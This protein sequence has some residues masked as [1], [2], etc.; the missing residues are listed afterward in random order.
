MGIRPDQVDRLLR[1]AA[2]Q[3]AQINENRHERERP[4]ASPRAARLRELEDDPPEWL[5]ST[6]GKCPVRSKSSAGVVLAWRRAA[7][8]IEDYRT[9]SCHD[10]PTD[11]IG[12][13]PPSR[14]R[15][16]HVRAQRAIGEVK[17][18]RER[19]DQRNRALIRAI[20]RRVPVAE[21]AAERRPGEKVDSRCILECA[22]GTSPHRRRRL[23]DEPSASRRPAVG[24]G[25]LPLPVLVP[26]LGERVRP[27]SGRP[28]GVLV[29]KG[30]QGLERAGE[31]EEFEIPC[32]REPAP[33]PAH[34]WR[35]EA[36]VFGVDDRR[37]AIPVQPMA[38]H[39]ARGGAEAYE[40]RLRLAAVRLRRGS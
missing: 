34:G 3:L 23:L 32:S 1:A 26:A 29:G 20:A 15:D 24:S 13:C 35:L 25:E 40:L 11:A 18:E 17:N 22:R 36:L 33:R 30:V 38:E 28:L 16:V 14:S 4:V 19:R 39:T 5:T 7:L 27:E 31:L 2:V 10:S 6:I 37:A 8:A 12:S 9:I 21:G